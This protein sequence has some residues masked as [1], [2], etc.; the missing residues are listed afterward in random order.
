MMVGTNDLPRVMDGEY[1]MEELQAALQK[2]HLTCHA[3]GVPT[4]ALSI[5]PNTYSTNEEDYRRVWTLANQEMERWTRGKDIRCRYS[6]DTPVE[7]MVAGF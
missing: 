2:L 7:N 6:C 5:P 4:L 1:S 3:K